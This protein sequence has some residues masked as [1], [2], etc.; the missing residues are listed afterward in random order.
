MYAEE[1][2]KSEI[3]QE[4]MAKSGASISEKRDG[5]RNRIK[6]GRKH[7]FSLPSARPVIAIR[8]SSVVTMAS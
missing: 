1:R 4:S 5:S 6:Q 2:L 7:T 8:Q 3:I